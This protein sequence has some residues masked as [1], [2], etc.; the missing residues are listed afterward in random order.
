[1]V[2]IMNTL[3]SKVISRGAGLMWD[4]GC[5]DCHT[6]GPPG[7]KMSCLL[8]IYFCSVSKLL[9]IIMVIKDSKWNQRPLKCT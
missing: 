9:G 3:L 6:V 5:L 2:V 7:A 1:M 8:F 4:M